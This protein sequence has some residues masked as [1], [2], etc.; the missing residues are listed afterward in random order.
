VP[1][2][3]LYST[4]FSVLHSPFKRRAAGHLGV[5]LFLRCFCAVCAVRLAGGAGVLRA[6]S[7]LGRGRACL[8]CISGGA[9]LLSAG[10]RT[11]KAKP[12]SA[13]TLA[14]CKQINFKHAV[15][16]CRLLNGAYASAISLPQATYASL[17]SSDGGT[18]AACRRYWIS[19]SGM[20]DRSLRT[21]CMPTAVPR[22]PAEKV[23]SA[24]SR[25]SGRRPPAGGRRAVATPACCCVQA[26][27][28]KI[29]L[30]VT[31][32]YPD[33]GRMARRGQAGVARGC[34]ACGA[35]G[36]RQSGGGM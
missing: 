1:F 34:Y 5:L 7:L 29:V 2:L 22:A 19:L 10:R 25:P 16:S 8:F 33:A 28:W 4:L 21:T 27:G 36:G 30:L 6:D 11:T 18:L 3:P 15:A 9:H 35:D 26:A 12:T 13:L 24:L 17:P 31:P 23:A 14:F 32:H 20:R